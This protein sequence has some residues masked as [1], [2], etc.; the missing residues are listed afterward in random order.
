MRVGNGSA[1]VD[2]NGS[3]SFI[4]E[5]LGTALPYL[6]V[7]SAC[8]TGGVFGNLLVIGAVISDKVR[9]KQCT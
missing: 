7:L 8:A 4:E 2:G 9:S 5:N 6:I 1:R 3:G